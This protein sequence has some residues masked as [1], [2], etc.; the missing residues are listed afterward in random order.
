MYIFPHLIKLE[1][2]KNEK[3]T[4]LTFEKMAP[5]IV[6]EDLVSEFGYYLLEKLPYCPFIRHESVDSLLLDGTL[7]TV[8][9]LYGLYVL[10]KIVGFVHSDISPFNLMFSSI[11]GIWKLSD[12]DHSIPIAESLKNCRIAGTPSYIA[13]E[14]LETGI[15][16]EKSDVYSL[17]LTLQYMFSL[18]LEMEYQSN[19]HGSIRNQSELVDFVKLSRKMTTEDVNERLNVFTALKS[20]FCILKRL[21]R[22]D[23]LLNKM[24]IYGAV[25][26]LPEIERMLVREEPFPEIK[27]ASIE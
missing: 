15:F 22:R 27:F 14:S 5:L 8:H 18:T 19:S 23:K 4:T 7:L 11:D 12:F 24:S 13:P 21:L 25:K 6:R 16:T 20:A 1:E 3:M 10:H 26:L 17:G 2:C 9:I